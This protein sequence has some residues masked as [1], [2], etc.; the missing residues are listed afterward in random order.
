MPFKVGA[1]TLMP[2][3]FSLRDGMGPGGITAIVVEVGDQ[4]AAYVV[5]DGNN[6]L[7]GLREKI[8]SALNSLGIAEGEV[9]TTD[10]HSVN[11]LTLNERGYHPIGEVIDHEKLIGYIKDAVNAA[12]ACLEPAKFGCRSLTIPKVR[13]I[14]Q[15]PLE[16]LCILPDKA[17]Q[18]AKKIIIPL[19]AATFLFLMSFLLFV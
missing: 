9:F 14:G 3:E 4:K 15:K 11:A 6:M 8:L 2:N 18:K 16:K 13:V 19:F 17:V 7:S 1:S 5:I 12:L 10:T